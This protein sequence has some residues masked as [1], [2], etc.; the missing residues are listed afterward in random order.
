MKGMKLNIFLIALFLPGVCFSQNS[1][2]C[3]DCNV[4]VVEEKENKVSIR[5]QSLNY[6][7]KCSKKK[8]PDGFVVV[9]KDWSALCKKEGQV[10]IPEH[11]FYKIKNTDQGKIKIQGKIYL[12]TIDSKGLALGREKK[13]FLIQKTKNCQKEMNQYWNRY[14]IILDFDYLPVNDRPNGNNAFKGD[15]AN[16]LTIING[17]GVSNSRTFYY[18]GLNQEVTLPQGQKIPG[19]PG[20]TCLKKCEEASRLTF[21]SAIGMGK[22]ACYDFCTAPRDREYC[23]MMLHE[24]G[25]RLSLEDEYANDL[26]P[27]RFVSQENNPY[28]VMAIPYVGFFDVP[29]IVPGISYDSNLLDFYPRH[30]KKILGDF[31]QD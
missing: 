19:G 20:Q 27:D 26:C 4:S 13:D 25:H 15:L 8:S 12:K 28:S 14:G 11:T 6:V 10:Y 16:T 3:I 17:G 23:L 2:D 21:F 7:Q 9:D 24:F 30:L 29:E 22:S 5:Q 18:E 31:C 1:N